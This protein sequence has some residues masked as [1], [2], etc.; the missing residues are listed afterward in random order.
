[1]S[2]RRSSPAMSGVRWSTSRLVRRLVSGVRSSWLA[3]MTSRCCW[4]FEIDS[5]DNISRKLDANRPT[6]SFPSTSMSGSSSL[7]SAT[8]SAA[9]VRRR[10]GAVARVAISQATN[11]ARPVPI[12][13]KKKSRRRTL[14]T[15]ASISSRSRPIWIAPPSIGVVSTR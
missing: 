12:R 6:S 13:P 9:A 5:D 7:V 8:C 11:A 4:A 14:C 2:S 10:T 15:A 3:S 1:M